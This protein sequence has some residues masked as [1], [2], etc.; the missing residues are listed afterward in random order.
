MLSIINLPN[1]DC[2]I[3]SKLPFLLL[4][5]LGDE[6]LDDLPF[7]STTTSDKAALDRI[8]DWRSI[9]SSYIGKNSAALSDT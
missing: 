8:I 6:Y 2:L 7:T 3:F 9:L 5:F 1:G 4:G